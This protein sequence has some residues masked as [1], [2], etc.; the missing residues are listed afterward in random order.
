MIPSAPMRSTTS[1]PD[2]GIVVD[3]LPGTTEV[4][5]AALIKHAFGV[6][7]GVFAAV[8]LVALA[9]VGMAE[10]DSTPANTFVWMMRQ[11]FLPGYGP[12][13]PGMVVGALWG[14]GIGYVLGFGAA[15]ARNR[16]IKLH[17]WILN[18]RARLSASRD[19]LDE[20][21]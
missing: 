16:I 1:V 2:D 4:V 12:T 5:V 14:L 13:V 3:D 7:M 21:S 19:V 10:G 17:F 15:L 20:I 9:A 18:T 8:V 11:S 6:A